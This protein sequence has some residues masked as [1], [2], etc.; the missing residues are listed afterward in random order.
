MFATAIHAPM[1]NQAAQYFGATLFE[2]SGVL[3]RGAADGGLPN[4]TKAEIKKGLQLCGVAL[5]ASEDFEDVLLD[6]TKEQLSQHAQELRTFANTGEA[7]LVALNILAN[8]RS[9]IDARISE[10]YEPLFTQ[11]TLVHERMVELA[12]MAEHLARVPAVDEDSEE[13]GQFLT[14]LGSRAIA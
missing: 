14:A 5:S 4:I 8:P 10:M 2:A 7:L 12:D 3:R 1:P 6:A 9:A 11:F 13:F